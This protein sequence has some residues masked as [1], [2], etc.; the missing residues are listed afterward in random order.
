MKKCIVLVAALILS[1]SAFAQNYKSAA[2]IKL[3]YD[4]SLSYK[5]FISS[6]NALD[7]GANFTLFKP[8][9]FGVNASGYYEWDNPISSVDGLSWYYGVGANIGIAIAE[10]VAPLYASVNG[11]IGLEYKIANLP[12]AIS[13]D[14][15]PGLRL[16]QGLG[17]A[18]GGGGLGIKYTF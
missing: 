6:E 15:T 3:G 8:G 14:W 13:L 7:F 16:T 12:L 5:T 4:V 10:D 17:F 1:V 11:I 9:Y 18:Y 2:G